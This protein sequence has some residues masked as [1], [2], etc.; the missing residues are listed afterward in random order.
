MLEQNDTSTETPV[1]QQDVSVSKES[2][3]DKLLK[4]QGVFDI[5]PNGVYNLNKSFI[6]K[7]PQDLKIYKQLY[8]LA[9][10]TQSGRGQTKGSGNGEVS[11]YW[12]FRKIGVVDMRGGDNPDLSI[13]GKN[14]EIKAYSVETKKEGIKSP[15]TIKLGKFSKDVKN[16][17]M[18]STV[19]GISA[20]FK[21]FTGN[22]F[23]KTPTVD[24]WNS[25]Y[26]IESFQILLAMYNSDLGKIQNDFIKD[27]FTKLTNLLNNLEQIRTAEDCAASLIK[28]IILTKLSVKPGNGNY[29]INTLQNGLVD[30]Y[31]INFDTIR[32]ADSSIILPSKGESGVRA[33][34]SEIIVPTRLLTHL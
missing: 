8:T 26:L 22:D 2:S 24:N 25:S 5:L 11:L 19:F 6:V 4:E 12:L 23:T 13:G 31:Q 21:S 10:E 34:S 14:V 29:I 1:P 15:N 32:S 20:L 9:P 28:N 3:F 27:L 17:S 33:A 18:L 7:D 30:I 16:R